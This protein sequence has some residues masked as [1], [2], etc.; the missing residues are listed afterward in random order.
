M[1]ITNCRKSKAFFMLCLFGFLITLGIQVFVSNRY[2]VKGAELSDL[3]EKQKEL[4]KDIYA[5]E[6]KLSQ[7]SSLA[8]VESLAIKNGFIAITDIVYLDSPTF[9]ANI[10]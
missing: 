7:L 5:Q 2:A 10:R 9:A 6:L 4:E 8:Y 1:K 3:L